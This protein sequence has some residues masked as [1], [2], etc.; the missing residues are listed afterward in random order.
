MSPREVFGR[1]CDVGAP[2][3]GAVFMCKR[4]GMAFWDDGAVWAFTGALCG[5][6]DFRAVE[7]AC[8]EGGDCGF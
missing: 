7:Y 1:G 8:R 4:E 2:A 6:E 5:T 3:A